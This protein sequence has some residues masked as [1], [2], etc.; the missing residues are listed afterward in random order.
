VGA[1]L[2]FLTARFGA[3]VDP[4]ASI[5]GAKLR[6]RTGTVRRARSARAARPVPPRRRRGARARAAHRTSAPP[7]R[8]RGGGRSQWQLGASRRQ[9]FTVTTS[10]IEVPNGGFGDFVPPTPSLF[11]PLP[12]DVFYPFTV[13]L[14]ATASLPART[15]SAQTRSA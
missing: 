7:A 9:L 11:A 3:A 10:F 5:V 12:D 4:Q 14:P 13:N 6:Y 8:A 15:A 1:D 2:T